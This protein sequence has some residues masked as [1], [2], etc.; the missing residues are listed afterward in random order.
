MKTVVL[1]VSVLI[2]S[3]TS[4]AQKKVAG[5]VYIDK[6]NDGVYNKGEKTLEGIAVSNQKDVVLTDANGEYAIPLRDGAFV[7]VVKPSGYQTKLDSLHLPDYYYH[8]HTK[9]APEYLKYPGVKPT[10]KAPGKIN[11]ALYP[12]KEKQTFKM[13]ALGDPQTPDDETLDYFR[14]GSVSDM[15]RHNADFFMV[16]G[17]IADDFLEIYAREKAIV[18]KLGIPG[19]HVPGN[20]DVNYKSVDSSNDFETFRKEFGP[21]YYSFNYGSV[22]FVVLNNIN[23]KGWNT[24]ENKKGRYTGDLSEDQLEWLKNDL[25]YVPQNGLIVINSHIPFHEPSCNGEAIKKLHALLGDRP[26]VLSLS[27][28]MHTVYTYQLDKKMHWGYPGKHE[29]VNLGATCGSWWSN[30]K[31]ENGIPVSTCRDGSPKGYF[32]FEF[33]GSGYDYEF[34]PIHYADDF[35]IRVS[36]PLGR[37]KQEASDSLEIVANWFVGKPN[38]KVTVSIN[39]GAAV[40]MNNYTGIDP[41]YERTLKIRETDPMYPP[42]SATS[43]HMW[44]AHVPVKL[45]RGVHKIEV[46]GYGENDKVYKGFKLVEVE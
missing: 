22:H 3:L 11:F 17:D 15:F 4:M 46:T 37:I 21:D 12:A 18:G 29:G 28:H 43:F 45:P 39:R 25:M 16:H 41:F 32:V 23:Y 33:K 8:H 14:D 10:G 42:K 19:Y 34:I 24:K 38:H 26:K 30:P 40:T 5:V 44:K 13:L 6:N 1:F 2:V 35:Q 9:G 20:H 36:L 27:G 7:Y 31:N